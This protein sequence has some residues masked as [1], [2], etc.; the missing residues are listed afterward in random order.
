M[1]KNDHFC[2][3]NHSQKKPNFFS[4]ALE[5]LKLKLDLEHGNGQNEFKFRTKILIF[6]GAVFFCE[7]R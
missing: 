5:A 3:K 4:V 6:E 2:E 1:A 7:D